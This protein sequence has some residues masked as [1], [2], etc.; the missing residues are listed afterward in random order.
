[1][2]PLNL[3]LRNFMCYGENVP[4]LSFEGIRLVCLCGDNGNGKSALLDAM[5]WALWGKARGRTVDELVHAGRSDMEVEFDFIVDVQPYR[6]IR[7]HT[8]SRVNR[9]G[10]STLDFLIKAK[11]GYASLGSGAIG[12]TETKIRDILRMDY[13][14]FINSA[15][16][17]QGKADEFTQKRPGERK[18]VLS[19][20]LGRSIYDRLEAQTRDMRRDKHLSRRNLE[21]E[22]GRKEEKLQSLETYRLEWQNFEAQ[23]KEL[24][25]KSELIEVQLS[26][27]GKQ[28]GELETKK[29]QAEEVDRTIEALHQEIDG[30]TQRIEAHS[31]TLKKYENALSREREVEDGFAKF[32]QF[33]RENERWNEK[34]QYSV[35][36]T[37]KLNEVQRQVDEQKGK[38][39]GE[40]TNIE[41]RGKELENLVKELPRWKESA[42]SIQATIDAF[43]GLEGDLNIKKQQAMEIDADL[44]SLSVENSSI[45]AEI[46]GMKEKLEMLRQETARCPLCE[47]ELGVDGKHRLDDHY[48]QHIQEKA[49]SFR[50]N[51]EEIQTKRKVVQVLR[52]EIVS[53]EQNFKNDLSAKQKELGVVNGRVHRAEEARQELQVLMKRLAQ[54]EQVLETGDFA[55][56]EREALEGLSQK[57]RELGYDPGMHQ[58][59]KD[60]VG[61]YT[62]YID[63]KKALDEAKS[64]VAMVKA[65][66]ADAE[67]L[68][69]G[70]KALEEEKSRSY[71]LMAKELDELPL[72]NRKWQEN[73]E[74]SSKLAIIREKLRNESGDTRG[75]ISYL[76]QLQ[77]EKRKEVA[78]LKLLIE[79]EKIFDDLTRCFGKKG[80]QAMLI[81][82]A[83]PEI[84]D[85]ANLLLGRLTE[86]RLN[87]KI[88]TQRAKKGSAG[89]DETLDIK[90]SDELGTRDY[91]LFSG[92]EAFRINFALRLALSRLL[93]RRAGAPMPTLIIDEGFGTQDREGR[94]RLVQIIDAIQED[95]EKIIVITHIEE[96]K[97][98]FPVRI[99]VVKT[100][101]GS[102]FSIN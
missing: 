22:I 99:E 88:E 29:G 86:N 83:I 41:Q 60:G 7:K 12:Q 97:E 36:I 15:Y 11:D 89:S 58:Q 43:S 61:E 54:L 14:T 21:A 65:R 55:L 27:I 18:E 4:P 85:E 66:L 94:D 64:R 39:I 73:R 13:D 17:V 69:E 24:A 1:M 75:K 47:T 45:E 31:A 53:G 98:A 81:E 52:N 68:W 82:T 44:K 16:L 71:A 92:G 6:V 37:K 74:E 38:L 76:E 2:I 42:Q 34:L 78:D 80:I 95:F 23:L 62:K 48:R 20:I 72:I 46:K 19:N 84:E 30:L 79:E 63:E 40:K 96:V 59:S 32:Q 5:T 100:A 28:K 3:R 87:L 51:Q 90:I 91:A 67:T 26:L 8:R 35:D 50:A 70:K 49:A 56:G 10:H 102:T 93:A 57:Y 77:K 101:D 33:S 25:E 9:S